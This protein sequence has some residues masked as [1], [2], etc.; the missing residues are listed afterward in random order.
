MAVRQRP[1][2]PGFKKTGKYDRMGHT[3]GEFGNDPNVNAMGKVASKP[4]DLTL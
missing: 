2:T 1:S 3:A 4:R